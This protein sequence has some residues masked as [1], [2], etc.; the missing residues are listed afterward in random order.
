MA[1]RFGFLGPCVG[2]LFA[3]AV[4]GGEVA[5]AGHKARNGVLPQLVC[6]FLLT[7]DV[8]VV[9]V[10]GN[11]GLRVYRCAQQ[12]LCRPQDGPQNADQRRFNGDL[13]LVGALHKVLPA[14]GVL[15][16]GGHLAQLKA[17]PV[18]AQTALEAEQIQHIL[19]GPV[20]VLGAQIRVVLVPLR[21][22]IQTG[23][24]AGQREELLCAHVVG[25]DVM[26]LAIG[27]DHHLAQAAVV[28]DLLA[29]KVKVLPVIVKG[30]VYALRGV[31][32]FREHGHAQT[33]TAV[34][35]LLGGRGKQAEPR[36]GSP[37]AAIQS[38]YLQ[39]LC[40]A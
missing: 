11:A 4:P 1:V 12:V 8:T 29:A 18:T 36:R 21:R 10:D 38:P 34:D 6:A 17:V 30:K 13:V 15:G 20:I 27:T 33:R 23:L 32:S 25:R 37:P 2:F 3:Q 31:Q 40:A 26:R 5:A 28:E 7:D 24:L 22:G 39:A 14:A 9:P 35:V 16:G 19:H